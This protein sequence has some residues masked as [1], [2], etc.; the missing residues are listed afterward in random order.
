MRITDTHLGLI[1]DIHRIM[2]TYDILY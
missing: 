1:P 2:T